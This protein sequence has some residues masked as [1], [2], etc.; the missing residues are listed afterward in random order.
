E[1]VER[2]IAAK[3]YSGVVTLV[4]RNGRIVHFEAQ[5][6]MDSER[7]KPMTRD[8]VFRLASMSKVITAVAVLILVEDG[9][10]RLADP[11]SRF[12]REYKELKVAVPDPGQK[13]GAADP[14]YS[15]VPA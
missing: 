8:A 7:A 14:Q 13:P 10:V 6:L 1:L 4:A 9:K 15:F 11:V 12:V 3:E 2:E 5:G